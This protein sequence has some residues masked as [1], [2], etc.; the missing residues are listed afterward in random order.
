M[1]I[2]FKYFNKNEKIKKYKSKS[3]CI[4]EQICISNYTQK[5]TCE[6]DYK[7]YHHYTLILPNSIKY[8]KIIDIHNCVIPNSVKQLTNITKTNCYKKCITY[9]LNKFIF[10][11]NETINPKNMTN[12]TN[13]INICKL[14]IHILTNI[15]H[16]YFLI[17]NI[18]FVY[19][20]VERFMHVKNNLLIF[21]KNTNKL[22]I[23]MTCF[24][25]NICNTSFLKN[26]HSL[27]I[28]CKK[29]SSKLVLNN[30]H[31]IA[32][33][34][35]YQDLF[36]CKNAHLIYICN[37]GEICVVTN[38]HKIINICICNISY[39]YVYI[40]YCVNAKN[41][42]IFNISMLSNIRNFYFYFNE[43]EHAYE[44][45]KKFK[46]TQNQKMPNLKF[47]DETNLSRACENENEN[48]FKN[49]LQVAIAYIFNI[50]YNK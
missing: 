36:Y 18:Y 29:N 20:L 4:T 50:F 39:H 28:S 45:T 14:D 2:F 11:G 23:C 16:K 31:S 12:I 17:A 22:F 43:H 34:N 24:N 3:L 26:I 32:L 8:I 44:Y 7:D 5:I 27:T 21:F 25:Y 46:P 48:N 47:I 10:C 40:N 35:S 41:Y 33:Q 42:E 49:Y 1:N 9:N 38:L 37:F 30:V 13:I 15:Y 6:M 19:L